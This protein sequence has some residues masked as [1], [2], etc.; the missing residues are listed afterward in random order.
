[1]D[2]ITPF[3][4]RK[5]SNLFRILAMLLVVICLVGTLS[6]TAQA[7]N[8]FVITDGD[9]V[10][11]HTTYASDP[12]K[13]LQEAGVSLS[14][15]DIYTTESVDGVSEIKVQ[16]LQTI[17]VYYGE[18]IF[19]VSSFG[20]TLQAL[21]VRLG[22]LVNDSV[23]V[24]LPLDTETYN[25][26]EVRVD[27]I[28]QTTES[29]TVEVPFETVYCDD[30]TLAVGE[31][32]V[33]VA[34]KPGQNCCTANVSYVNGQET[35]RSIYE[36]T[37]LVEP[38][39]QVV[40]VGTGEKVGQVNDQ[41]LIGNGVIVL[42]SGEVLTYTKKDTFLATAYTHM[43]AGCDEYT[44]NGTKVKWGVVAVDP[45]VIPYGTRMFIVSNDGKYVYGLST[46]EDCGGAI[47]NKRLD[48]Y[49]PTLE[50]AFQFGRRNCT[51]YFLGGAN[52][53]DN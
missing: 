25:G 2:L 14:A 30:P 31:E 46:A 24:S 44:S 15:D 3:V 8:T 38:V 23:V 45:E 19:E 51:V 34:G 6:Q 29:Y 13:V 42:P 32:K 17:K 22:I 9:A 40:A 21:F 37:V 35:D 1:M 12:A 49:M 18:K 16:R 10:T 26:M 48:L 27:S 39:S 47:I 20:E 7:A 43:D 41:P 5:K 36:Q 50:E 28:D 33:L 4:I 11:V 53:K 52:W